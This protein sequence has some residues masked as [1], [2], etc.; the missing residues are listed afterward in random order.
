MEIKQVQHQRAN[1]RKVDPAGIKQVTLEFEGDF[2]YG[3]L[4]GETEYIA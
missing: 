1:F 2:A 4:K 3:M